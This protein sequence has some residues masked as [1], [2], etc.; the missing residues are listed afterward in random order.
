MFI[1]YILSFN[2]SRKAVKIMKRKKILII[3]DDEQS[4]AIAGH[5]LKKFYDFL[6]LSDPSDA[7]ELIKS[8]KP[9]LILLDLKMPGVSGFDVFKEFSKES[10]ISDIPV[11][12]LTADNSPESE[13]IGLELGAID[14]ITKPFVPQIMLRRIKRALLMYDYQ[15]NLQTLVREKIKE[16]S[17]L[18][19]TVIQS[20]ANL[21]ESR[22]SETGEHVKRTSSCVKLIAKS[23]LNEPYYADKIDKAYI[24]NIVMAAPLHDIGKIA[25]S[26]VIL[27]KPGKLTNEEF[28]QMK[29]HTTEGRKIIMRD[30]AKIEDAEYV[31]IAANIA[32]FHHEKW[33]G[34]G[35]PKGLKG[36]EIPICARIMAIAD[37]FDALVSKRC[38]KES[39]SFEQAFNIIEE[40]IGTHFA[41]V[42]G[43]VFLEQ[44]E[45]IIK[46]YSN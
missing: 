9:D 33:S 15:Q 19:Q 46:L 8:E 16:L 4:L 39:M 37:V 36:E 43:K 45:N 41:P 25:V 10:D 31:R 23:L 29:T 18:Q 2:F 17:E 27:K 30:I 6:F 1:F 35:Y 11:I 13:I 44:K 20:M 21:I 5:V 14:F 24:E 40:S 7:V 32:E 42:V 34:G 28:A 22:D 38:Y 12:F 26:D 3:D